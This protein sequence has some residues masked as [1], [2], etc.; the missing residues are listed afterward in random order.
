MTQNKFWLVWNQAGNAPKKPH[1]TKEKAITE[2]KRLACMYPQHAYVVLEATH[3]YKADV[4]VIETSF[5]ATPEESLAVEA[6]PADFDK[7][8]TPR[9]EFKVGDKV[10]LDNYFDCIVDDYIDET[11]SY[12]VS[13]MGGGYSIANEV[14]VSSRK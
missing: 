14:R 8:C 3:S 11:K 7:R 2:A 13:F 6:P 4:N 12:K 1:D 5:E 10:Y 9:Q